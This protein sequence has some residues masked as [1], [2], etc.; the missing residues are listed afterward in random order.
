MKKNKNLE[1][2]NQKYYNYLVDCIFDKTIIT[3]KTS[4]MFHCLDT[5]IQSFGYRGNESIWFV[6]KFD[7]ENN[8][9]NYRCG[10]YDNCSLFNVINATKRITDFLIDKSIK[11]KEITTVLELLKERWVG[12]RGIKFINNNY[13]LPF[14]L[15]NPE[16]R[17][18][19]K[20][21]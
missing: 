21:Q 19:Q 3:W 16:I 4:P 12:E 10:S 9:T 14:E 8:H 18:L 13:G 15:T 1:I 11:P 17:N 5:S 7:D 20:K 2:A 6:F